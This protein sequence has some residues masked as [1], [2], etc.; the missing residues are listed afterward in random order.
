MWMAIAVSLIAIGPVALVLDF[1]GA[2]AAVNDSNDTE[3][4]SIQT[5]ELISGTNPSNDIPN[6]YWRINDAPPVQPS[7]PHFTNM[8]SGTMNHL[9]LLQAFAY[10][11]MKAF[12]TQGNDLEARS[13]AV[14]VPFIFWYFFGILITSKSATA[15]YVSTCLSHQD[16]ECLFQT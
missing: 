1:F 15:L 9:H 10:N 3:N 5:E 14:S 12:L 6:T 8:L 11:M 2:A 7:P 13:L 4:V 16:S